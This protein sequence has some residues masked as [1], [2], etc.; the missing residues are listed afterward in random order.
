MMNR[1]NVVVMGALLLIIVTGTVIQAAPPRVPSSVYGTVTL[2]GTPAPAGTVVSAWINGV[3]YAEAPTTGVGSDSTYVLDVPGDIPET[4]PLE[5]GQAGEA[6]TFQIGAFAAD[7]T[8]VWSRGTVTE[9]NLTAT[10][11]PTK[12]VADDQT[13]ITNEDAPVAITLAAFDPNGDPL[14]Y[15]IET[16]PAHGFLSGTPPDLIYTPA[17]DYH[18]SDSF[19]FT[20]N[21]GTADSNVAT[22]SITVN[23]INDPP[24]WNQNL[25]FSNML[26]QVFI[27][28]YI[29]V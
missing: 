21:D 11:P 12:P 9:V 15:H 2:G 14:T 28:A 18:G 23:S 4:A 3:K 17:D 19:T 7:Q 13:V 27:N 6:I 10:P 26:S 24:S 29:Q 8:A 22:V 16:A 5:G 20:A 1:F 25:C